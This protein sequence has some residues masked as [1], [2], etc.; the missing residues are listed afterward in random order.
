MNS[1]ASLHEPGRVAALRRYA[2]LDTPA[3]VEFDDFTQLA[4]QICQTPIALISLVDERRQWF[5]SRVGLEATETPRDISFCQ[6]ALQGPELLEIPDARQDERFRLNPLVKREPHIRFYAGAPLISPEGDILGTLCV[7]DRTPRQLTTGQREALTRL[8]RQVMAQLELRL[9]RQKLAQELAARKQAEATRAEALEELE[10]FFELGSVALHWVDGN[11]IIIW[12]NR[13]ELDLLGYTRDEYIGQPIKKFHVE[14]PVI[15][16]I[17]E[18]LLRQEQLS[19]CEAQLLAKDGS[20]KTVSIHSSAVFQDGQFRHTRCFSVDIT[21]QK[22]AEARLQHARELL[23]AVGQL[24][25][26]YISTANIDPAQTFNA[27]LKLIL[28]FTASEYGFVAEVLRNVQGQPYLKTHAITNIAWNGEMRAFEEKHR[29]AGLEFHNL[30]TLFG[31]ALTTGET[32]IANAPDTDPRRG[33]LPPGHP[34][35]DSFLGVPIKH[36]GE[37]I[38]MVGVSNRPGGYDETLV[39]EIEPLLS[40][41]STLIRGFQLAKQQRAD[42]QRILA[43]NA[44]LE[45]RAGELAKALQDKG[46]VERERLEALR[47]H[48]AGLERRVAERTAELEASRRQFQDLFEFAPDALVMLGAAGTVQRINA[49]AEKMFGWPRAELV[50]QALEVLMPRP[51]RSGHPTEHHRFLREVM[52][53][54]MGSG[55]TN[56][57]GLRKDGTKFPVEISL[58]PVQTTEGTLVAAAVRDISERKKLEQELARISSHEQERLAHEL[59]DHLGAYLAGIAF[60]FKALSETLERRAIPEAVTAQQLVLQVNACIHQVR[61]FARLLA[62]VNL[63][64]GGLAA[65]LSQLGK[66]VQTV[67][68]IVCRVKVAPELPPLAQEQSLQLYRIAQECTRNAVQHGKAR[69]I[70]ISI[71]CDAESLIQTVANDGPPWNPELESSLGLGLRIMRHRAATLG[72]TLTIQSNPA[73]HT[74]V[75]CRLPLAAITPAEKS[76]A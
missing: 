4:S 21:R 59:H 71:R 1:P 54:P 72:G 8:S 29:T 25:S 57:L 19:S 43:L 58:S 42:Q 23:S 16:S 34:R 69:Q 15:E 39:E 33:G 56:L 76:S 41:Y 48:S 63:A 30:N 32:V 47:E 20:I 50:G 61:N 60:R 40:T 66:E 24:Q 9:S 55:K 67:F 7:M 10:D 68:N 73:G 62:P 5:K 38:A 6:H 3:E 14:P 12:A 27:L 64:E 31:A 36:G 28:R 2:V 22:E 37:L 11:G 53:Q 18:R 26:G 70:T 52:A 65:G 35:M 17:L 75:I 13:M 45:A 46:R 51:S 49:Q 74:E 44:D